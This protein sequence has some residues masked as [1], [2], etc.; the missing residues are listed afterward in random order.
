MEKQNYPIEEQFQ[1]ILEGMQIPFHPVFS[2]EIEKF[3][4]LT[5]EIL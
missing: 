3:R 1:K 2:Q 5:E 4:H